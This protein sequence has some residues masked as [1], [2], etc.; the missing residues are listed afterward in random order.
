MQ[1]EP[2]T[3]SLASKFQ[4][5]NDWYKAFC[6]EIML[7]SKLMI[8]GIV[9]LAIITGNITGFFQLRDIHYLQYNRRFEPK[10]KL[11][12]RGSGVFK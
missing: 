4:D 7:A 8:V 10:F 6:I 2:E 9:I 3:K 5:T 1:A 12:F 11:K